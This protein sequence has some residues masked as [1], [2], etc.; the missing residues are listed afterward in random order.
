LIKVE[1]QKKKKQKA[2]TSGIIQG[3]ST[4]KEA[5]KPSIDL[6]GMRADKAL[7]EVMHYLDRAIFRGMNQVELVHGKGDGILKD[8]IHSYLNERSD[9]KSFKLATE[10]F[11]GAGCTV[12]KLQ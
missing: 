2:R 12:V 5:V 4:L 8:Q 11:G 10:D 3:D 1:V 9:I 6:R 7:D